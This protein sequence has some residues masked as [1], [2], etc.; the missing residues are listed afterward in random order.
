MSENFPTDEF[1]QI[2]P[3][4]GVRRKRGSTGAK[5]LEFVAIFGVS[6]L[7]AG[8]GLLGYQSFFTGSSIDVSAISD[9]GKTA[10]DPIRINETTVFDGVG[11]DGLAGTVAHKLIDKGWNVVTASNLPAGISAAKTVIYINSDKLQ[12]AAKKLVSDL[13]SYSVEVSNQYIDPIT[14]VIGADYK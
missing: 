11:K 5:L 9:N 8:G 4:A 12:D 13:G 14:V 2:A 3:A 10:S 6:A 1:D 7:V